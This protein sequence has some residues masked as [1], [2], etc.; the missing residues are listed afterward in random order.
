M[1]GARLVDDDVAHSVERRVV[2]QPAQQDAR[3]AEQQPRRR[4]AARL[5]YEEGAQHGA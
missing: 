1:A 2:L 3:G 4:R 5:P